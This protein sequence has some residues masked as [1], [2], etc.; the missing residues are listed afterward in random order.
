MLSLLVL[1]DRRFDSDFLTLQ[2]LITRGAL[3]NVLEAEMHFDFPNASWV[4]GYPKEYTPGRGMAF[5]LGE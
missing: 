2:A 3:G 5:D 1:P 4:N